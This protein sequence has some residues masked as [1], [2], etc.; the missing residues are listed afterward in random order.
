M[1]I[2]ELLGE[3]DSFG[4]IG[5]LQIDTILDV[6]VWTHDV[7]AIIRHFLSPYVGGLM[8]NFA[9][10]HGGER[11]FY[12]AALAKLFGFGSGDAT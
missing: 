5:A 4:I 12:L 2:N 7:G 3:L 8:V 11:I 1:T 9:P 10:E 6:A